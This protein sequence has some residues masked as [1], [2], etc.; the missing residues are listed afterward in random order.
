MELSE[1]IREGSFSP[2][3][4]AVEVL[5]GSDAE[6]REALFARARRARAETTGDKIFLYG[7]V[8]F[9]TWCR[10]DCN[11]CYYRRDNDIARYRKGPDEVVDAAERLVASGVN[12]V[13]LTMGEDPEYLREG[14]RTATAIIREIK[15]RTGSPVMVSSGV[16]PART[17]RE[18]AEAGA[19]FFALYQETHNRE[20][21]ARL[22]AGQDYNGRMES[23]LAAKAA[24]MFIEEGVLTGVG[25]TPSDLCD[26]LIEMGRVGAAQM[27]AMSFVPQSGSPMEGRAESDRVTEL[28]FIALM[29][30]L[31]PHALIPASL[32]V[33]GLSGLAPRIMAGANVVTSIVP[34]RLGLRGVAQADLDIDEG[35]RT[36]A[37]VSEALKTLGLRPATT[38]EYRERLAE[39]SR[40]IP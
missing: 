40:L 18:F 13:D 33:D 3:P 38:A 21:F 36:V 20:L 14:H 10:N 25:E 6:A 24:G 34:P 19:E 23:K 15:E 35:A 16:V 26:S 7:F 5:L 11:F 29:R 30:V 9:S 28:V 39:I 8:Y 37:G 27:R 4:A 22:R 2:S 17:I 12:L 31:Y 1:L 32:D